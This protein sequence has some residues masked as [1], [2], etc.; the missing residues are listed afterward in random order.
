M[1]S[2]RT[3][4]LRSC[5]LQQYFS[6]LF[7]FCRIFSAISSHQCVYGSRSCLAHVCKEVD[8]TWRATATF[9]CRSRPTQEH[10]I[11][12][13]FHRQDFDLKSRART[14]PVSGLQWEMGPPTTFTVNTSS[15]SVLECRYIRFQHVRQW[16][17]SWIASFQHYALRGTLS[18][19]TATMKVTWLFADRRKGWGQAEG[20]PT[21]INCGSS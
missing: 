11:L 2:M 17:L 21:A 1:S 18:R 10:N 7:F 19:T 5:S 16:Y 12:R 3:V 14:P 8:E 15:L 4:L 20:T 6:M 13:T 9:L